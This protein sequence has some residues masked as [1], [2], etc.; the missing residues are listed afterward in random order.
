MDD[1]A[2]GRIK[3][4][5]RAR[6]GGL[7]KAMTSGTKASRAS[8][9]CAAPTTG[10]AVTSGPT[11]G[12]SCC[13]PTAGGS[14]CGPTTG[15]AYCGESG[16]GDGVAGLLYTEDD[17]RGV[18]ESAAQASLGCGNPLG[19]V[20]LVPGETVL[21]L[22]SGGGMDVLLAAQRVGPAGRAYGLDFTDEMLKLA[23]ENQCRAGVE[24]AEFLKG[25]IEDI[26]LPDSSVD[27]VISN[28]VIN[29]AA[30]KGKVFREV[31]RV[32][33][34]GGRLTVSDT[35]F[36]G[37]PSLIPEELRHSVEAWGA[38]VAGSLEVGEY[39]SGLRE[40]GFVGASL[41]VTG[42]Y[43]SPG[44]CYGPELPN[45][46]RL[47]SGIIRARKPGGGP[48]ILRAAAEADFPVIERLLAEAGLPVEGLPSQFPPGYQVAESAGRVVGAAGVEV[49]GKDGLLRSVVVDAA[50]RGQGIGRALVAERLE[51]ARTRGLRS[52][53]LLT[54]DAASYFTRFGF[55]PV[56]R[57]DVPAELTECAEFAHAC[58]VTASVLALP[59]A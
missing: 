34:P 23:R 49:Y 39:L 31:F 27:V 44:V 53:Y 6:Y 36:Q 3:D 55:K 46:V 37:D 13:G 8:S 1:N 21:D 35:M 56:K 11:A 7:A 58:P 25:D 59:L 48:F 33:R 38:C 19:S 29:L 28:C 26:P 30:D 45:G 9:C 15:G 52:V 42:A 32:L 14:C 12:G 22:G 41:E 10:P 47:V 5:I 17:L 40:A 50:W 43:G 51:G 16:A 54:T 57:E 4:E 2:Q 18:P 20:R 24:N